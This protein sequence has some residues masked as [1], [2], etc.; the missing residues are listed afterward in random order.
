MMHTPLP[1][2]CALSGTPYLISH[3]A[4]GNCLSKRLSEMG[5]AAQTPVSICCTNGGSLI[6]SVSGN[7]VAVG[8]GVASKIFVVE[9]AAHE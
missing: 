1:L 9:G 2:S 5:F 8:K 4:A 3:V 6:V 7:R